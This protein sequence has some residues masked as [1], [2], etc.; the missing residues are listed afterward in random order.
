M[1]ILVRVESDQTVWCLMV[2][3]T[4]V[5]KKKKKKSLLELLSSLE[6]GF[7]GFLIS[8]NVV[9]FWLI[10]ALATLL[11]IYLNVTSYFFSLRKGKISTI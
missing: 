3:T 9:H 2:G 6:F 7:V 10:F 4:G 1:V 8:R 11:L 5:K